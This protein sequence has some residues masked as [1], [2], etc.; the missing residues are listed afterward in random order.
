MVSF[1]TMY[2]G[3]I[4]NLGMRGFSG[5]TSFCIYRNSSSISV[6]WIYYHLHPFIL[7]GFPRSNVIL[8]IMVLYLISSLNNVVKFSWGLTS[9]IDFSLPEE[10]G[11]FNENCMLA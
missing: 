6:F 8:I 3:K 4:E 2:E 5:I 11:I 1:V 10:V 9:I 7:F